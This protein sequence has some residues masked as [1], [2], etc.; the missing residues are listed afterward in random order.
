MALS[1]ERIQ[2]LLDDSPFIA[3]LGIRCTAV[4]ESPATTTLEL[5]MA[6]ALERGRGSNQFH[7]GAIA[8]L[9]D[10]AGD[11]AVIAG[12]GAGVPTIDL[13]VDYLRP[14]FGPRLTATASARRIGR[15]IGVADVDVFDDDQRLVAV[16]RGCFAIVSSSE[17]KNS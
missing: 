13:R 17:G 5:P 7:G 3:F 16:G 12:S 9:I 14:A 8:S 4:S 6:P 10:T 15:T 2:A 11:F 1:I